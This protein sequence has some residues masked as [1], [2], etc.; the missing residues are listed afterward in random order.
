M[1]PYNALAIIRSSLPKWLGGVTAGFKASGSIVDALQERDAQNRAGLWRRCRVMLYVELSARQGCALT[2]H[3]RID[4][5]L[6]WHLTLILATFGAVGYTLYR[7]L[8]PYVAGKYFVA[9]VTMRLLLTIAWPPLQF[10]VNL[11]AVFL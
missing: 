2:P 5:N 3:G 1:A 9:D 6:W 8:D 10:A 4:C 7:T 11:Y